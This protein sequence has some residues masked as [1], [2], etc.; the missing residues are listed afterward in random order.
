M[1]LIQGKGSLFCN[2]LLH[3]FKTYSKIRLQ[4]I[5]KRGKCN[6]KLIKQPKNQEELVS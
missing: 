1:R 2:Y 3:Y 5:K 6:G 4:K